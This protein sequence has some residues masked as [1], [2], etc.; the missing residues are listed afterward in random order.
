[1]GLALSGTSAAYAQGKGRK[2]RPSRT[3]PTPPVSQRTQ[4][5]RELFRAG[6]R[7]YEDGRFADA[8]KKMEAAYRL[9]RS[10]ELAYNVGRVYE[11]MG[12]FKKA[13]RFFR[14]Y[15]KSTKPGSDERGA[16]D[17]R[18]SELQAAERRQREQVFVSAPSN[19]QLT[20]E[21]RAF[22]LRGVAMFRRDHYEAAMQAFNAAH[23]F[24]PFPE[25]YFNMAVT[26]ERLGS[27]RDARDYYREYLRLRPKSPDRAHVERAIARLRK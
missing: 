18:I 2:T 26:A 27:K 10:P 22:F 20:Q 13:I 5:A 14:L 17:E 24:A 15:K 7:A 4:E 12:E 21:A 8:G 25:L 16:L 9:T 3:E 6:Q 19:D 23:R 11:R 1:M